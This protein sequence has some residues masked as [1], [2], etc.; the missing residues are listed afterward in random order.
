[1]PSDASQD[2]VIL[3]LR[4]ALVALLYVFLL[5]L[6]LLS[7][8]ELRLEREARQPATAPANL[9]VVDP[10][11]SACREGDVMALQPVTRLGRVEGNT[12]ILDDDSVSAHHALLLHRDGAWWVRDEG[13]TNGTLV[14]GQPTTGE[15]AIN[16]GD[17]L[18]VGQVVLRLIS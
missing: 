15:M 1:V 7:Q 11:T 12:L 5:S 17:E 16:E 2:A 14:N 6:V 9:M 10:G 8:R 3:A 13:S 4:L 18:Q